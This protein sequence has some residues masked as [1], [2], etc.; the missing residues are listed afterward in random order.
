MALVEHKRARF[1]YEVTDTF[2]AGAEL[3]GFEVKALRKSMGTLE[4]ARVMVRGGEAFLVGASIT[5]FQKANA[6][7]SYDPERSRRL[8]LTKK[9]VA[10]LAEK[11]MQKGLTIIPIKWYN[12]GRK[13]K[14]EIGVARRKKQYDKRAS[15]KARDTKRQIDRT[16]KNQPH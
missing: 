1:D 5:P 2:E 7:A 4:G 3:R 6:P 13:V 16:L 11:E 12:R 15:L 9:E 14:L 10:L 8:L